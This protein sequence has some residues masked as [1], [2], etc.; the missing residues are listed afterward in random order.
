M[1]ENKQN[2]ATAI[3]GT[4]DLANPIEINAKTVAEVTYDA[5]EITVEMFAQADAVKSQAGGKAGMSSKVVAETDY[6]FQTYLGFMAII[7]VN[8]EYDLEDLK[9]IKGPDL[10]EVMRIGRNFTLTKSGATSSPSDSDEQPETTDVLSIPPT[11]NSEDD[12]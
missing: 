9:R 4:L 12:D 2:N 1:E 10:M 7:A 3:S 8:P 11:G 5:N 6:G